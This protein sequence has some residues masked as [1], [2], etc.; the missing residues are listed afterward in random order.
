MSRVCRRGAGSDG[1]MN[2]EETGRGPDWLI[3][4]VGGW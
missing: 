4:R 2:V 3:A 1:V